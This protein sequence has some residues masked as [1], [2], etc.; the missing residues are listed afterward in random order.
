MPYVSK[1]L[2]HI[3]KSRVGSKGICLLN[4]QLSS[5]VKW[6]PYR[7]FSENRLVTWGHWKLTSSCGSLA[8]CVPSLQ[9]PLQVANLCRHGLHPQR[10][11][12]PLFLEAFEHI[13]N[14]WAQ[15]GFPLVWGPPSRFP[16]PIV[17]SA[18]SLHWVILIHKI[19]SCPFMRMQAR[20]TSRQT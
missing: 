14:I 16:C 3:S 7:T 19:H 8:V 4:A 20:L 11:H 2:A 17:G 18:S 6:N 12:R 15:E 10:E 13:Q 5:S 1:S 9:K